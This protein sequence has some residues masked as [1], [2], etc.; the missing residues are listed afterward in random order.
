MIKTLLEN[1]IE[2]NAPDS[3]IAVLLS[4]GVDSIS[5]AFA[6]ANLGKKI[7]A[8]S[9]RLDTHTSYDFEKAKEIAK[10]FDWKFTEIIIPTNNLVEDFHRL[11]KLGCKS[12]TS[13]ECTYPFLYVYPQI[14]QKYVISGWAADGYYGISKKA[15]IN[16]KHTQELFDEFRD[17]YFKPDKCANYIWHK[18]V[19]D[20]H[21]KIFVTPYLND[22]VKQFFYSKSWDELNKP[23][24]KH[25]VRDA[26]S[27]FKLIGNVKKHLNLQI[28]SGIIELF[29]K[30]IDNKE[31]NFKNRTRMLDI[32][33]DWN[34][35]NN[36]STATLEGFMK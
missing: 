13:V 5:V 9:F 18:K 20:A 23:Y 4:G 24:Q 2:K 29:D 19:S 12:K 28:D 32:C 3:E 25:H 30:L 14:S 33:R 36:T 8:Y 6:A 10:Q 26:F 31:I 27:Q 34:M 15:Q 17:N 16:Y 21:R 35:L 1:H 7:H 11:I 22:S